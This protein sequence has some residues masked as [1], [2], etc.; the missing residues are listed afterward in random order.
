MGFLTGLIARIGALKP[1]VIFLALFLGSALINCGIA[2]KTRA[3]LSPEMLEADEVEYFNLATQILEGRF[4]FHPRRVA[5]HS[6]LLATIREVV[7]DR[8]LYVQLVVSLIFSL[9]APLTYLLARRELGNPKAA[10]LAGICVMTW[11]MF[12][13][14]GSTL[15]SETLA[16][17]MFLATLLAFP[18]PENANSARAWRWLGAG[19]LLGLCMHVRPMYL[20]YSP[21]AALVAYWRGRGGLFGARSV[22]CLTLGCL[23]VVLPWSVL[24]STREGSFILLTSSGGETLAGGYNPELM[25]MERE[26]LE[27]FTTPQGRTTWVGPG[28]WISPH[29]TGYLSQEELALPYTQQAALLGSRAEAWIRENKVTALYVAYCKLAYMWGLGPIRNGLTQTLLGDAPIVALLV[30]GTAALIRL[31]GHLR[32]LSM[33][34]TLLPFVSMAALISFGSWRYRQPADVGLIVLASTLPWGAE[35]RRFLEATWP[36][37]RRTVNEG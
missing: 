26:G 5:G 20:L 8:V 3:N 33:F 2:Y 7:G 12:A 11:P 18:G 10:L 6:L 25:R 16:L 27:E 14:Y 4:E 9:T 35:V 29:Q 13:Y 15:Y 22:A 19:A 1:G 23:L 21:M 17:P 24:M 36:F 32:Q 28:K 30:L 34:W 31:R 37:S